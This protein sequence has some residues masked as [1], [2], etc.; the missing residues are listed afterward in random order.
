MII[1]GAAAVQV[2]TAS[3]VDPGTA[4]AVRDASRN[5]SAATGGACAT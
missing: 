5:T 2:G 3:F 4:G 1:A